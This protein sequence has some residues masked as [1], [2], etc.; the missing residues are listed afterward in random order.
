V[1]VV[2]SVI[3]LAFMISF[4]IQKI[5]DEEDVLFSSKV[6]HLEKIDVNLVNNF[7]S[8]KEIRVAVMVREK[9]GNIPTT[10][11]IINKVMSKIDSKKIL[12]NYPDAFVADLTL[13]EVRKLAKNDRVYVINKYDYFKP[14]LQDAVE[15]MNVPE[16]WGLEVDNL[17]LTGNSQTVC[18]VDTGVDF[19]HPDLASKNIVGSLVDCPR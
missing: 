7:E 17:P 3:L 16:A 4:S 6:D 14:T 15:I 1:G 13:N 2:A 8:Q 11:S 18:I 10:D 5:G 19:T 9:N 12:G